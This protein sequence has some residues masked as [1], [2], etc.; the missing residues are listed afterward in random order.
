MLARGLIHLLKLNF[1]GPAGM[2]SY[3]MYIFHIFYMIGIDEFIFFEFDIMFDDIETC[4][5]LLFILI[6][7]IV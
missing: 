7:F 1:R 5:N 6:I 2:V 4:N 3:I